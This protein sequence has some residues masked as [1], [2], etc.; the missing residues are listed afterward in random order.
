MKSKSPNKR[1]PIIGN[2]LEA[3]VPAKRDR[4]KAE[5]ESAEREEETAVSTSPRAGAKVRATFHVSAELLEEARN[6]VGVSRGSA[7]APYARGPGGECLEERAREAE[8][9]P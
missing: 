5:A 2:D 4:P 7:D 8:K 9:G 3:Y 1:R 6:A